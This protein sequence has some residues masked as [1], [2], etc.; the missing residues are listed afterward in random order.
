MKHFDR[1]HLNGMA[2]PSFTMKYSLDDYTVPLKESIDGT[3]TNK[4]KSNENS[5]CKS[6]K[7]H[8]NSTSH[9][10]YLSSLEQIQD[11][12]TTEI[13]DDFDDLRDSLH[14]AKQRLCR[15]GDSNG[16]CTEAET[17]LAQ[18]VVYSDFSQYV[19]QEGYENQQKHPPSLAKQSSF[20]Q[21]IMAKAA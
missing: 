18:N 20:H 14:L 6:R 10:K 5:N 7:R 8:W 13:V 15:L 2:L 16:N 1:Q 9:Q 11:N 4:V 12:S 19:K 3:E 21:K 17:S